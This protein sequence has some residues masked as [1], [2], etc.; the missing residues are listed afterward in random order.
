[1]KVMKEMLFFDCYHSKSK[2]PDLIVKI[3][4]KINAINNYYLFCSKYYLVPHSVKFNVE[5]LNK[6]YFMKYLIGF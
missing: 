2:R 1:M 5:L 3:I 6:R 4:V